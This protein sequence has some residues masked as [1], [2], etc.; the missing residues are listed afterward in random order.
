MTSYLTHPLNKRTRPNL[1]DMFDNGRLDG[2]TETGNFDPVVHTAR[3]YFTDQDFRRIVN[4]ANV[5]GEDA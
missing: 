3:T 1:T 5:W 2:H 4:K